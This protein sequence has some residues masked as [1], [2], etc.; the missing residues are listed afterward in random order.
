MFFFF[1]YCGG[2]YSCDLGFE[3]CE[4]FCIVIGLSGESCEYRGD[5]VGCEIMER[6]YVVDLDSLLSWV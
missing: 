1:C 6:C 4:G 5:G 3:V 2:M